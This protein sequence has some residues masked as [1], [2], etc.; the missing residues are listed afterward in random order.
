LPVPRLEN[1][2]IPAAL[3]GWVADIADRG[4][5]PLEYPATAA[6]VG[7]SGLI[8]RR[9]ALRPKRADDWLVVPNLWGAVVGLP[10]IQKWTSTRC[11]RRPGA[12]L[13]M[14]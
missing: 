10:G 12:I 8:G 6:I 2:L 3:R 9:I 4:S 7:L 14:T 1:R 13:S 11:R 5:F